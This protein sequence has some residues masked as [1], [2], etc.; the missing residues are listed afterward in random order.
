MKPHTLFIAAAALAALTAPA[1][2]QGQ[3]NAS[4]ENRGASASARQADPDWVPRRHKANKMKKL[5]RAS[6]P[7]MHHLVRPR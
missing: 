4:G 1:L 5:H 3:G 2:A 7:R 6:S